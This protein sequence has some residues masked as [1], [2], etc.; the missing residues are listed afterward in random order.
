MKIIQL[1]ALALASVN[2]LSLKQQS[3][4]RLF[5]QTKTQAQTWEMAF[6]ME[7]KKCDMTE[8]Q[9]D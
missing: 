5:T 8:A 9:A 6:G 2:A 4:A 1:L 7:R 3:T